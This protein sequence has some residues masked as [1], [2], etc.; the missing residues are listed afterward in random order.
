MYYE[1]AA[2]CYKGAKDYDK[3]LAMYKELVV[4]N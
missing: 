2:K 1:D 4:A 3:A